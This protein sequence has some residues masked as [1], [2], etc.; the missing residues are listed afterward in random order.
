[1]PGCIPWLN[2]R[3]IKEWFDDVSALM[4]QANPHNIPEK[5]CLNC[6]SKPAGNWLP[7]NQRVD[8]RVTQRP[9]L[10]KHRVP[11]LGPGPGALF[12][13]TRKRIPSHQST[14]LPFD[15]GALVN[16]CL[17]VRSGGYRIW[18][19]VSTR[20]KERVNENLV[21]FFSDCRLHRPR[22]V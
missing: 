20:L 1:M 18:Q 11:L 15:R 19:R 8:E 22:R 13:D 9:N 14:V 10:F 3:K 12:N 7:P 21:Q 16:G 2:V 5:V 4:F 17:P 6:S